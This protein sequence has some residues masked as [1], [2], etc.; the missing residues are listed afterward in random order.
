MNPSRFGKR[1]S[2]PAERRQC[3]RVSRRLVYGSRVHLSAAGHRMS[4]KRSFSCCLFKNDYRPFRWL[5]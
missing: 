4:L 1:I 5:P 3:R 2:R